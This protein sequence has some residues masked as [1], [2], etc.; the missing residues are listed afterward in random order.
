MSNN[1]HT[2]LKNAFINKEDVTNIAKDISNGK[3]DI[4][5]IV[6]NLGAELTSTNVDERVKG[7][8]LLS[9]I[10]AELPRDYL[11]EA[12]LEFLITFFVDRIKDHHNVQP[13]VIAG[14]DVLAR[15]KNIPPEKV[16]VILRS[17]FQDVVCQSQMRNERTKIFRILEYLSKR[18]LAILKSMSGDFIYGLINCIEGERDPRNLNYIFSFMAEILQAYN[19]LHLA[20]EMFEVFACYFPVDFNPSKNDE[21]ETI[22]RDTLAEKLSDCLVANPEFVEW[23]IALILEK[24]DTD[25]IVAK[26]DSLDLL[27]KAAHT[28]E[29]NLIETHFEDIW[30]GLKT[31][32]FPDTDNR[33][34]LQR[35]FKALRELLSR[36]KS[37]P[38]VSKHY[39]TFILGI[40]LPHLNDIN[41][42]LF[43]P[44]K[45]I[46]LICISTEPKLAATKILNCLLIKLNEIGACKTAL[47]SNYHEERIKIYNIVSEIFA[48]AECVSLNDIDGDV[49]KQIHSNVIAIL[50]KKEVITTP[51]KEELKYAALDILKKSVPIITEENRVLVYK[52]LFEFI[53]DEEI[54]L[55]FTCLIEQMGALYPIELQSNVIEICIR[56]FTTFSAF[57]KNKV[58]TNLVPLVKQIAFTQSILELIMENVF[59]KELNTTERLLALKALSILLTTDDPRFVE[60]LQQ[61]NDLI[62]KLVELRL[63][64]KINLEVLQQISLAISLIIKCLNV[65]EQYM[66]V[67]MHLSK[68]DLQL[69]TDLYVAN[70]LLSFL[71][72][73]ISLDDHFEKLIEDLT[74]LSLES[75]NSKLRE[76][77]HFLLCGLSNKTDYERSNHNRNVIRKMIAKLKGYIKHDNKKAVE[78]LA[79]LAKG[80]AVRGD[81][82][83]ADIIEALAELLDNPSLVT[84][85][86]LA[87]EIISAECAHL[88]LPTVLFLFK[89]KLFHIAFR[90]LKPKLTSF[91]EHH[92]NAFIYVLK[93]TP[94]SVLKM[95]VNEIG[96]ILIK[97]LE[98]KNVHTVNIGLD[99][100]DNFIKHQDTYFQAHLSHLM[101]T[102]LRLATH[103]SSMEVRIKALN[104]IYDITKYP[105]YVL[106]PL[107]L[108]AVLELYETL[109]DPKRLVR[110]AAVRARNAWFLV[111][112][113]DTSE[114]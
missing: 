22:T 88:H 17:L 52:A 47:K 82:D 92:I 6:E 25:L 114:Q 100:C 9:D 39:Q 51:Q 46:G 113:P 59:K 83:I 31:V 96:P 50:C 13:A 15:M 3:Y 30:N 91:C 97:S 11:T 49:C 77:S 86:A 73:D 55:E 2:T 103:R 71:H 106:L 79:W 76:V 28:F 53:M 108:D 94:H 54:N 16:P 66:I 43:E 61:N 90:A 41:Q 38:D 34:I 18:H 26:T 69:A 62:A 33:D 48:T 107:K 112:A 84:A 32:I 21:E 12:Q 57:V 75:N 109:D 64:V 24:L 98:S 89:Q 85:A 5:V 101:K 81:D 104:I 78:A 56:K 19:L 36:A 27:F 67:T 93:G 102:C 110:N 80:L 95:N 35:A 72:K 63:D 74:K 60:E 29:P 20:E 37:L 14:F 8:Q 23:T 1:L 10:L 111:G 58:Y 68:L 4:S 45:N 7:T 42:R 70:G 105:T 87:F 40:I 44:A 65:A 99:M